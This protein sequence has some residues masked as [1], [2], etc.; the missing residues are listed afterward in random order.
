VAQSLD[1]YRDLSVA[2]GE[3]IARLKA[4][5]TDDAD[6][7]EALTAMKAHQRILQTVIDAEGSLDK[8]RQAWVDGVC[9]ELDLGAARSE[10]LARLAAWG[11]EGSG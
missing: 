8:R 2:L 6:C 4:D 1:L 5:L 10:I 11:S 7:K 3:R 9:T